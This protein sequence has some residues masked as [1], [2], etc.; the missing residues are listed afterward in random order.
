[1]TT[2][3][4]ASHT[5]PRAKLKKAKIE[6]AYWQGMARID[7]ASLS[8]TLKRVAEVEM[9]CAELEREIREGIREG[10]GENIRENNG[11]KTNRPERN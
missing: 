2:P 10:I 1:M 11:K 4:T 8:R 5:T 3:R 7:A 6:R 9:V